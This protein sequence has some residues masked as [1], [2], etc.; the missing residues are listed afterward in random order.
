MHST[1]K[2]GTRKSS[3]LSTALG[4]LCAVGTM[5]A[6]SPAMAQDAVNLKMWALVNEGYPEFIQLA[7]EAF[8]KENPG[9]NVE[10]ESIPNE[11]YKTAIQVALVGSDPPDIYFNWSGE[12]AA[13]LSRSDL[14]LD[15]TELG[16]QEGNYQSLVTE[17]WQQAFALDGKQ[18]GIPT[19]AVSKYFYYN[20][21]YFE[22]HGLNVPASFNEL[23]GLCGKIREIDAEVVPLPLGN[24][25]RWKLNHYIT[26]I[27]ERVLGLDAVRD[28][29][30]LTAP[31]EELFTNPQYE[32]AWETVL[33]MKD[34]KCF[35][36][37]P[38]ATSPEVSRS[39]FSAEISPMIFC[40]TWCMSIFDNEGFTD[41]A[42]FRFPAID[43]GGSDGSTNMVIPQ[44]LQISAKTEHPEAAVKF[45]SFLVNADMSRLFAEMRGA[46]P[47]NPEK[48]GE[49]E[50]TEQFKWVAQDIASLSESFSVLDVMLEAGV[51]E[52]YLDMGVE[53]LNGTKTPAEAMEVIRTAAID[54]KKKLAASK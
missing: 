51:S 13:R 2:S 32:K 25:E 7:T 21:K 30:A 29:Y 12:D 46:I 11:A 41:Y 43:G 36:D 3:T 9:I 31:D 6:G 17:A 52:A 26:V 1:F 38:N 22:E 45:A 27:N 10:L 20:T 39:L 14:A 16:A 34:A 24:S 5:I 4:T 54:G 8:Q 33:A 37:A 49:M 53:V 35:Q 28:D 48:V 23:L 47:S 44:G 19:D 40:G 50:A 15:I 18:Y 42:L